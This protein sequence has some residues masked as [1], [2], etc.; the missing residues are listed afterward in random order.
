MVGQVAEATLCPVCWLEVVHGHERTD[1]DVFDH[2]NGPGDV[3][4]YNEMCK[5]HRVVLHEEL[6]EKRATKPRGWEMT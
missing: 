6:E 4:D 3:G 5:R 1:C 2:I